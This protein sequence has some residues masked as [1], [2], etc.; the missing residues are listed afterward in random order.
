MRIHYHR[1]RVGAFGA[2]TVVGVVAALLAV[3]AGAGS[4]YIASADQ[5]FVPVG[6]TAVVPVGGSL[7]ITVLKD[8]NLWRVDFGGPVTGYASCS[9]T[10]APFRFF[11]TSTG[12][13]YVEAPNV[14]DPP[15]EVG[16][17]ASLDLEHV[18][19]ETPR[20]PLGLLRVTAADG[21]TTAYL[22]QSYLPDYEC[23]ATATLANASPG[24]GERAVASTAVLPLSATD[25]VTV[26]NDPGSWQVDLGTAGSIAC[27][28]NVNPSLSFQNISNNTETIEGGP[29]TAPTQVPPGAIA[30]LGNADWPSPSNPLGVLHIDA[31]G[32]HTDAYLTEGWVNGLECWGAATTADATP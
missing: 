21:Q 9:S 28:E 1:L 24:D 32:S 12:T 13:E 27:S 22:T 19:V 23:R 11:N 31:P 2:L 8:S 7:P 30:D 14:G 3:G 4:T 15:F 18:Y 5:H 16:P 25:P 26:L 29:Y 20:N 10:I 6:V 17:G